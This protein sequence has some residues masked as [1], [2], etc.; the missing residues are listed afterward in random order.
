MKYIQAITE[1]GE[2]DLFHSLLCGFIYKK[3]VFH[4]LF[5][6]VL[7]DFRVGL[8]VCGVGGE[9]EGVGFFLTNRT[10]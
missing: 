2:I 8:F 9:V 6:L 4:S 3:L 5:S 1:G 7:T 10:S